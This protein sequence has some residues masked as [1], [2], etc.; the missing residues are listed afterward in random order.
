CLQYDTK[1]WTF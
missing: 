1:P